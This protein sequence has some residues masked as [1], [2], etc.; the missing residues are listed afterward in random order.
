MHPDIENYSNI[1]FDVPRSGPNTRCSSGYGQSL[2]SHSDLDLR[3]Q[4]TMLS[5]SE[6]GMEED[7]V[8]DSPEDEDSDST[9]VFV[10]SYKTSIMP[11]DTPPHSPGSVHIPM[12]SRESVQYTSRSDSAVDNRR[13]RSPSSPPSTPEHRSS[14]G[15]EFGSMNYLQLGAHIPQLALAPL[16]RHDPGE[17]SDTSYCQMALQ[18][19]KQTQT[20]PRPQYASVWPVDNSP[21]M[22]ESSVTGMDP[23]WMD[24]LHTDV[25]F[26]NNSKEI[27]DIH[28]NNHFRPQQEIIVATAFSP[29]T[30]AE[31]PKGGVRPSL[32]RLSSSGSEDYID[33][34]G[35]NT[36]PRANISTHASPTLFSTPVTASH[37]KGDVS[38][39][40]YVLQCELP[41]SSPQESTML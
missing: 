38:C 21:N 31:D 8:F 29:Q 30:P 34:V 33:I 9:P 14:S 1:G 37:S 39:Q 41:P 24:G 19:P 25:G 23:A 12:G 35:G 11:N 17:E 20:S 5:L 3:Q 22:I 26:N 4:R 10:N 7:T 13:L 16:I 2:L 15:S 18:R 36:S 6:E 28:S 40:D 32:P 27:P